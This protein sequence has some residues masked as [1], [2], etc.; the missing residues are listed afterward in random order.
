MMA[1]LAVAGLSASIGPAAAQADKPFR[2]TCEGRLDAKGGQYFFAEGDKPLNPN[3][4][5]NL[6]CAH[7]TIAE[8]NTKSALK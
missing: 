2:L 4:D 3:S 1:V 7:V 5:D 8:K 6:V